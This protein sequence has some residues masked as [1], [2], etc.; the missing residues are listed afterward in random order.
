MIKLGFCFLR[1]FVFS[2]LSFAIDLK[3]EYAIATEKAFNSLN[4]NTIDGLDQFYESSAHFRDPISDV[5]GLPEI[6]KYYAHVYDKVRSIR[7]EF[8][9]ITREGAILTAVWKMYVSHPSIQDGREITLDGISL[10]EFNLATHK[11]VSHRDYYDVGEFVYERIPI[12]GSIIHFI[13]N[14]MKP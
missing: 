6:K 12:L 3:D 13:K 2:N 8:Q 5:Y 7:F 9:S 1:L 11:V 4:K 14:Q 10:I